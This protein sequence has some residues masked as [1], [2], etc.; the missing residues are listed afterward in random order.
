VFTVPTP[1][2][3]VLAC[4]SA[5]WWVPASET[6]VAPTVAW[7]PSCPTTPP[8]AMATTQPIVYSSEA[9]VTIQVTTQK[10]SSAPPAVVPTV[11]TTQPAAAPIVPTTTGVLQVVPS[12]VPAVVEGSGTSKLHISTAVA[13]VGLGFAFLLL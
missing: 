6:T 11:A 8:P 5:T 1:C 3:T 13:F 4:P 9:S 12:N 10:V 7:V 2:V